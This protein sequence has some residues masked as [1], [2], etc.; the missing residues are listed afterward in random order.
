MVRPEGL[1]DPN[2][3][4]NR[5]LQVCIAMPPLNVPPRPPCMIM[6]CVKCSLARGLRTHVCAHSVIGW[7]VAKLWSAHK[8]TVIYH[9]AT[10]LSLFL[11]K[12]LFAYYFKLTHSRTAAGQ[13][14]CAVMPTCST[15]IEHSTVFSAS[16]NESRKTCT[17]RMQNAWVYTQARE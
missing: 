7:R 1:Y 13:L 5:N 9:L 16:E 12:G 17:S 3:N 14:P 8:G 6:Q 10:L 15:Y 4:R 2:A 11:S